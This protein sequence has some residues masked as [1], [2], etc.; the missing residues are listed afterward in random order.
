MTCVLSITP[1]G[2]RRIDID[3]VGQGLAYNERSS[4]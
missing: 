4:D 3:K 2:E 1:E